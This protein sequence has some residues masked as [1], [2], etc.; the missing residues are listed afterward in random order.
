MRKIKSDGFDRT[1]CNSVELIP[2]PVFLVQSMR[3]IGYTL[4]TA[5]ADVIDNSIAANASEISV[6]YRWNDSLPWIAIIDNGCGMSEKEL[7]AAM[8]FGGEICSTQ[9]RSA[10]DLGRF[11]LGLKTAS[12]SQC[13]RLTVVSKKDGIISSCVWD[14]DVLS[15]SLDPKWRVLLP[16]VEML[17]KNC[18]V[19]E[20]LSK[21]NKMKSGTIVIW[22][23]LDNVLGDGKK[24]GDRNFSEV[25]TCASSHIGLVF[26]R[27]FVMEKGSKV[28]KIDF[29][30]TVVEGINPFGMAVPARQELQ[31]ETIL[32]NGNKVIIQPFVL[33][34]SSKV[35]KRD[36]EKYGG[37]D[38]YL[39][40]QGFY[41]YRNRRLIIKSTWFR[42]I[43]KTE[44]TKLL[45]I[46]IDIPNSLDHLWQLDVKKSSAYPPLAV[47]DRLKE[48]LP[49]LSSRGKRPYISRGT[50][51]ISDT[52]PI[53]RREF[54]NGNVSYVI[55]DE[56]PFV[57]ALITN[58]KGEVDSQKLSYLRIIS[59][60]FPTET[61]HVDVNNDEKTVIVPIAKIEETE[62]AVRAIIVLY[63]D[64][65]MGIDAVRT[66]MRKH[67][68]LISDDRFEELLKG[69]FYG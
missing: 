1:S 54:S 46:R 49:T 64:L 22:Q 59:G 55:N 69:E 47:L 40:N 66:T 53:W 10:S 57:K 14:V 34:H 42:I 18:V 21:L 19:D 30:N 17:R 33:P 52:V 51:A 23:K 11:G 7:Q 41:V 9:K 6:Q 16:S 61:F 32:I 5:L 48:L 24:F 15:E 4:E 12:L 39:H 44:L 67:E 62:N 60:A 36:Y 25:M 63:H 37:D 27:F 29:N 28:I 20:L 13:K 58:E 2:N 68:L 38:G 35:S 50:K 43:P 26:H 56:H 65:G 3:H 31:E 45:R 8:R